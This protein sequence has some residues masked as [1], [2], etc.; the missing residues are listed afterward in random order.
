MVGFSRFLVD[1]DGWFTRQPVLPG[2]VI[3]G[4]SAAAVALRQ[5]E[6]RRADSKA[7]QGAGRPRNGPRS[8]SHSLRSDQSPRRKVLRSHGTGPLISFIS[9]H[10][11]QVFVPVFF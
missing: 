7:R 3:R 9:T 4:S 2:D 11:F 1:D 10:L 5:R 6:I 8:L